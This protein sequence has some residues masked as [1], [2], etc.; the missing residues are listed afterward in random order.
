MQSALEFEQPAAIDGVEDKS[1]VART[2]LAAFRRAGYDLA[3]A[4]GAR[5]RSPNSGK[6]CRISV[7]ARN[8]PE[9]RQK[10]LWQP[11]VDRH[12]SLGEGNIGHDAFRW[13]MQDGVLTA[14]PLFDTETINP[15][16][17]AEE[18]ARLKAQQI[19]EAVA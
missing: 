2:I 8:A 1:R 9:R 12:H 10:R 18:I 17:W 5:K 15:D 7:L 16:I 14:S 19:A 6:N 3:Y 13:I 4:R 11:R